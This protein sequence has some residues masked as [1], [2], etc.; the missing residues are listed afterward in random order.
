VLTN[1]HGINHLP[2]ET[3][4]RSTITQICE[5]TNQIRRM[6]TA[7]LVEEDGVLV[8]A[9]DT[10]VDDDIHAE[11]VR[12]SRWAASTTRPRMLGLC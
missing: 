7:R 6:V 2:V 11:V 5:G 12:S 4:H 8:S 1:D 3:V 10:P 9:D